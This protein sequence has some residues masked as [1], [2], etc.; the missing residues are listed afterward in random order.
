MSGRALIAATLFA[1]VSVTGA[2]FETHW[3]DGQAEVSGYRLTVK[4]Y[5]QDRRGHAVAIFVTEPFSEARRVKAEA[6]GPDAV[7]ALKL[8]LVRDFQTGLYDY[9]TMASVFVRARDLSPLKTTFSSAEWCGHVFE[10]RLFFP[11]QVTAQY[12]SYFD[13]ES[14]SLKLDWPEG[15]ITEEGL[16]ILLR[17]L[18]G[19]FLKPG[20]ART[21]PFLPS[22]YHHR[23]SHQPLRWTSADISRS[24]MEPTLYTV[25]IADGRTGKFWI[26]PQYPHRI[27]RWE[28]APDVAAE[29]TGSVR[30]PYWQHNRTGDEHLL[31]K[32]GI[33]PL[34]E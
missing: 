3:R 23:L 16:W 17:G 9:N 19:E 18:R 25:R 24:A 5:G 31:Q 15:G 26:E 8:N 1:A 20:D 33:S 11:R 32:L 28:L 6:T 22:A 30:L 10:E 12:H 13:G 29:L 21:A 4:R 27:R 14:G 34:V 7:E 2:D